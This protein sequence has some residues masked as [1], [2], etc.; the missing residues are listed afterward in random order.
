MQSTA[1]TPPKLDALLLTT[2]DVQG[3]RT[4]ELLRLLNSVS[5]QVQEDDVRVIHYVL[6]QRSEQAAAALKTDWVRHDVRFLQLPGRV[7][8]SRARNLMLNEVEKDGLLSNALWLAFPDDD[9]W[10]P[11]GFIRR[12][13][14]LF[15]SAPQVGMATCQYSSAPK[16]V[17]DTSNSGAFEVL[18]SS[19]QFVRTVS[20]NTLFLRADMARSVGFFDERLGVGAPINGGED[21]DFALR[22][23]TLNTGKTLISRLPLVGHRDRQVWVRSTYFGGSLFALAR[24][25]RGDVRLWWSFVRKS[26]V[27]IYLF[28]NGELK[29]KQ[30]WASIR[31]A[32]KGFAT[33]TPLVEKITTP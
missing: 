31:C 20:S 15:F 33:R 10:Y 18:T 5:Q 32:L 3:G 8:L 16:A 19:G 17:A 6:L 2:C 9:A 28:A 25:A 13:T 7:S 21:L 23:F 1:L 11:P 27:G 12:M 22:A 26:L 30:L 14:T 24:A 29:P 4:D